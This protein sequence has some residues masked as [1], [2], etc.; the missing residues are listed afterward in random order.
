MSFE[1]KLLRSNGFLIIPIF[2]QIVVECS[3]VLMCS[4]YGSHV[5]R[6][7]LCLCKGVPLDSVEQ[8][9]KTSS[10][11]TLAERLNS[12]L[13]QEKEDRTG[14]SQDSFPHLLKF[15]IREMLKKVDDV[16]SLPLNQSGS[17]ILQ[18]QLSLL[19][20]HFSFYF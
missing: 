17:L 20:W 12:G 16:S 18:V 15:L 8:Y 4:S 1:E 14:E 2:W 9:H 19:I 3:A 10:L 7:L 13:F 11:S 5:L 6:T